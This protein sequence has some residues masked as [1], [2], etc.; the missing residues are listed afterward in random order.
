MIYDKGAV[1]TISESYIP[2]DWPAASTVKAY[3]TTRIGGFS[4]SPFGQFNLAYHV[5]DKAESVEKNRSQL[6]RD[7][8]L[9]QSPIWLKQVHGTKV[10]NADLKDDFALSTELDEAQINIADGCFTTLNNKVCIVMTADCLPILLSNKKGSWV[11]AV[12]AG[13]RGLLDGIIQRSIDGYQGQ[14]NDLIAWLGPC[15]SQQYFE[16]GG[17]VKE[18]FI[19][20][21][22]LYE[23]AFKLTKNNKYLCDLKLVA[24]LILSHYHIDCFGGDWCSYSDQA[25]FYSYRRDGQTGRMAS[26]I[27]ID[28]G[29]EKD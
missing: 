10:L 15:I 7:L 28:S 25:S 24:R 29:V 8:T 2:V 1:R 16:V 26:L 12:H 4:Q 13:W 22:A 17:E 23:R 18:A 27:W 19:Q 21:N 9:K 5:G 11:A 3:T 20:Q 6:V 14:T